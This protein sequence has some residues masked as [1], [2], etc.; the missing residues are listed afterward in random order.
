MNQPSG[1]I[2]LDDY[3]VSSP[4]CDSYNPVLIQKAQ[5]LTKNLLNDKEKAIKIFYFLRDQILYKI[6]PFFKSASD[7]LQMGYG[8]CV[9]KS[10]L[11]IA[12][13]RSIKIPSRF[14]MI[15]LKFDVLKP[16]FPGWINKIP[17]SKVVHHSFC[18]C[19]LNGKW[20]ACDC[21][22][23]KMLLDGA[24]SKGLIKEQNAYSQ[25]DWD[26]EHDLEAL[27]QWKID[28]KG[29]FTTIDEIRENKKKKGNPPKFIVKFFTFFINRSINKVRKK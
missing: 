22:F 1:D 23:D 26:G 15:H 12:M 11:Q 21:T 10:H 20:I 19:F 29:T 13:L 6:N 7:I 18:K 4:L 27:S 24:R 16:F 25:I 17:S 2:D 8:D 9:S 28:D 3:L 5:D 14:H